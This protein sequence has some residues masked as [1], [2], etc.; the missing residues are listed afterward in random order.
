MS[1]YKGGI[2]MDTGYKYINLLDE[3]AGDYTCYQLSHPIICNMDYFVRAFWM[4]TKR[5]LSNKLTFLP[6]ANDRTKF[7][8][9]FNAL[10]IYKDPDKPTQ[11]ER[12]KHEKNR[13]T[14]LNKAWY[15]I[16]QVMRHFYPDGETGITPFFDTK[17]PIVAIEDFEI[18]MS[19]RLPMQE[20]YFIKEYW[21]PIAAYYHK[22]NEG[23]RFQIHFNKEGDKISISADPIKHNILCERNHIETA[24]DGNEL[25][26]QTLYRIVSDVADSIELAAA[27]YEEALV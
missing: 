22:R 17:R 9:L 12:E 18:S 24:P 19:G 15:H 26:K 4:P 2:Y 27:I 14:V 20:E 21:K 25:Y 1:N 16:N 13:L 6:Y 11:E 3:Q 23:V 10:A 7:Q 5:Q 8:L